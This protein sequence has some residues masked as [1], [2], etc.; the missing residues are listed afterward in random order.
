M[1]FCLDLHSTW[2]L[3][4][5]LD[6]LEVLWGWI[7]RRNLLERQG[8][9]QENVSFVEVKSS[10]VKILSHMWSRKFTLNIPL[11]QNLTNSVVK[12]HSAK[13]NLDQWLYK[14]L[15]KFEF[16]SSF[17]LSEGFPVKNVLKHAIRNE[18]WFRPLY[19]RFY[20]V[21]YVEQKS[22][23]AYVEKWPKNREGKEKWVTVWCAIG[24][25]E[26]KLIGWMSSYSIGPLKTTKKVPQLQE[27]VI[28]LNASES[29]F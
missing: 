3:V 21:W 15:G 20:R 16:E 23:N 10:S 19:L 26:R 17:E 13:R 27:L 8:R 22:G 4:Q 1:T 25:P 7:V 28:C 9:S 29:I 2:S 5:Q 6:M 18:K 14:L 24:F 12:D 11:I